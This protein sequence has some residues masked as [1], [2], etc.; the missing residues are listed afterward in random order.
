GGTTYSWSPA[1]T[2]NNPNIANPIAAPVTNTIYNVIVGNANCT[3]ADSIRVN[4]YPDPVFLISPPGSICRND[5]LQLNAS[6]GN[7]YNWQ[8]SSDISNP[9]IANPKV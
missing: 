2:L 5:S 8:P 7:V 4:V 1:A 3:T 6:G 9:N